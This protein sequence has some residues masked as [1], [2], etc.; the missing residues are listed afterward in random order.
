MEWINEYT[1]ECS[2]FPQHMPELVNLSSHYWKADPLNNGGLQEQVWQKSKSRVV[3]KISSSV[4]SQHW[5]LPRET[6]VIM[7]LDSVP[8]P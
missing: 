4:D 5:H 3:W 1:S 8:Y 2:W 6:L 7:S